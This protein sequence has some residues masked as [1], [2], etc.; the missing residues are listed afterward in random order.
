MR[1]ESRQLCVSAP[2]PRSGVR[3]DSR[4]DCR[5]EG[6]EPWK[7]PCGNPAR[8]CPARLPRMITQP[9][10]PR[11]PPLSSGIPAPDT[12][13]NT[14]ERSSDRDPHSDSTAGDIR[15]LATERTARGRDGQASTMW[16]TTCV[17]PNSRQ[18]SF[19]PPSPPQSAGWTGKTSWRGRGWGEGATIWLPHG[20]SPRP[21][22]HS[23]VLS[24]SDLASGERGQRD[25]LPT[26]RMHTRELPGSWL[27]LTNPLGWLMNFS[28]RWTQMNP[29][30]DPEWN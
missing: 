11:S 15:F 14:A 9:V 23:Q 17:H 12:I 19:P 29:V 18:P 6:A 13:T 26:F 10:A 30:A 7:T 27:S 1:Q 5:G 4:I 22:P 3:S 8:R 2:S 21:S 24:E 25:W 20:P 28:Q 16:R